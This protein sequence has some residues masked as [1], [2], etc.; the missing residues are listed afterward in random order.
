[1]TRR[2]GRTGSPARRRAR[3]NG[4]VTDPLTRAPGA[5]SPDGDALTSD[6]AGTALTSNVTDTALVFEGGGMRASY[7]SALV[8]ELIVGGVF[9]DWVAG[10]SAG[11]SNTAN[12][13]SRDPARARA[14]FV[15]LVDDPHFGGLGTLLRG[16]GWFNAEYIYQRT[17]GPG[18]AL[19][20]DFDTYRANP[21]QPNFGAFRC[22]TGEQV[23]FTRADT[24]TMDELMVRV[25]ASSTMPGLM[26]VVT[27]DGLEYVDGALG[28]DG[29]IGLDRAQ[30]AGFDRFLVV[31][32]RGRDYVKPAPTRGQ[33]LLY[34]TVF[35]RRP[36]VV[37]ALLH[38][39]EGYNAVREELFALEEA[40]RAYLFVPDVMPVDN[41]ER[42]RARLSASHAAGLEQARRELP[43]IKEFLGL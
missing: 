31:L 10:I 3:D 2:V 29:G 24:G 28:A 18:Q 40:G 7:T 14:S 38:R 32:T 26:P 13:L 15:D 39:H 20:F 23:W 11:S 21:A 19:P 42:D 34:R 36:A 25:R 16:E 41:G 12:Y 6:A 43:A 4:C 37:D 33:E 17:G 5:A 22:D 30:R 8:R 9:V 35:R 27:I 1:M